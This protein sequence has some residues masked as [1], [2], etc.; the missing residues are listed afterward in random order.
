MIDRASVRGRG[1]TDEEVQACAGW[2]WAL[3]QFGVEIKGHD[4]VRGTGR[5]DLLRCQCLIA[6]AAAFLAGR[7]LVELDIDPTF[8]RGRAS[9]LVIRGGVLLNLRYAAR[10]EVGVG[11]SQ[12][13]IREY[14][15]ARATCAMAVFARQ[16][17]QDLVINRALEVA[18]VV[19]VANEEG[20]RS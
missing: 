17:A 16:R 5:D 14:A 2:A 8:V 4:G 1:A 19:V 13:S 9:A 3:G 10:G 18:L 11:E 6:C 7:E 20:S 12:I 15:G